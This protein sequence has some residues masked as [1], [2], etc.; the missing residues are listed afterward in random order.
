ML[1]QEK[2]QELSEINVTPFID[3]MLVLLI[4]FMVVTPLMTTSVKVE[5]PKAN[6]NLKQD[7]NKKPLI[8]SIDKEN[9]LFLDDEYINLPNLKEILFTKTSGENLTFKFEVQNVFDKN[10][11]DALNSFNNSTTQKTW[12]A[13]YN[14]VYLFSNSSRGRTFIGSFEYKF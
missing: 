7:E 12:D 14:N 6:E 4:I 3:V 10:Y 11:M 1:K 13:D 9:R 5:L 2:D 8:L